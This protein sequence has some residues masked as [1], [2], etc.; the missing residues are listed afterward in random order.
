ML[1]RASIFINE[2]KVCDL[3]S[4]EF[5]WVTLSPGAYIIDVKWSPELFIPALNI[6]VQVRES[7]TRFVKVQ[8]ATVINAVAFLT[9]AGGSAVQVRL[10]SGIHPDQITEVWPLKYVAPNELTVKGLE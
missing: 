5:T 1:R 10:S 7:E 8:P 2:Q 4:N 3:A 6:N 9:G